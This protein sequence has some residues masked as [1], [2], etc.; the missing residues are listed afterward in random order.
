MR[1]EHVQQLGHQPAGATHALEILQPV[2]ADL[3]RADLNLGLG[4]LHAVRVVDVHAC[5]VEAA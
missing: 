5:S 2:Q 3:A 4:G 1:D